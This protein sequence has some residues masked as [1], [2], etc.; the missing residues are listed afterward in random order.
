LEVANAYLEPILDELSATA[1]EHQLNLVNFVES[2]NPEDLTAN[3]RLTTNI[4]GPASVDAI[5]VLPLGH[6][7]T[8]EDLTAYCQRFSALP[9]CS[10]PAVTTDSVSHVRVDN[11]AGLRAAIAHLLG[12]HGYR[13]V[14]FVCG[15]K[16]SDEAELRYQV[17]RSMLDAHGIAFDEALVAPGEYMIQSGIDAVALLW[18]VRGLKPEAIVCVN[19]GTAFGVLEALK[20][21]GFSV[22]HDVAVLG[23][24]D[25][26]LARYVDPPLTTV[27][28]PLRELGRRA[29]EVLLERLE[30]GSLPRSEVLASELVIR[31]SCGC[32]AYRV[33][34]APLSSAPGPLGLEALNQKSLKAQRALISLGLPGAR[35]SHWEEKLYATFLDELSRKTPQFLPFLRSV[36]DDADRSHGDVSAFHKAITL[37]WQV[38][39]KNLAPDSWEWKRADRLLHAARVMT[40]G[41]AER[42][43]AHQQVRSVDSAYKL[44]RTNNALSAVIDFASAGRV[45]AQHLPEHGI[46][47]CYV[48]VYESEQPPVEWSRLVAGFC[49]GAALELPEGGIRFRTELVLP[50]GI[51]DSAEP[52]Q[53]IVGPLSRNGSSPGYVVFERGASAGF[54]YEN[55]LVQIGTMV[56]HIRLLDALV[57]EATLR[58]AAER[59]RMQKELAIAAQ[60]QASILPRSFAVAGLEIAAAMQPATEVGGDYYDIIPLESG[61]WIGIGDVAGHGLPTGLVMLMLQATISGVVRGAPNAP[62]SEILYTANAVLFDN[63]RNRMEQDEHVTLTLLHFTGTGQMIFAGAH[64]DILIYRARR[65]EVEVVQTPGAWLAA[66]RDLRGKLDDITLE[67]GADDVVLLYTDGITEARRADGEFFGP[68]RLIAAL[69]KVWQAPVQEIRDAILDQVRAFMGTQ[70]DDITLVVI[71]NTPGRVSS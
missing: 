70:Q 6:R 60:I 8:P 45:L 10:V 32:S 43:P 48:C 56:G 17:Y 34:D 26:E 52:S 53:H 21:R 31:D 1:R 23:F 42:G 59:A 15:P 36:L 65:G 7:L 55:L 13:R 63:I 11:E 38:V 29:L 12:V 46:P 4:A 33:S 19:D 62:P 39:S 71:R 40:S 9:V 61:T 37:L 16:G 35:D 51:P 25:V 57:R 27:R 49:S 41:V 44:T 22:P 64:E 20:A 58:E 14:A 69:A 3:R 50:A 66:A 68:E 2:L 30:P 18:D 67:L 54:V 24:D 28:Q 5:L 47:S